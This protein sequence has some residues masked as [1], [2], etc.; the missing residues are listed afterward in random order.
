MAKSQTMRVRLKGCRKVARDR[1]S[2]TLLEYAQSPAEQYPRVVARF[3]Q[4][5]EA[6]VRQSASPKKPAV[7][8]RRRVHALLAQVRKVV[9]TLEATL[10]RERKGSKKRRS[11]SPPPHSGKAAKAHAG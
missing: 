9:D 8:E 6:L 7:K 11:A 10:E 1:D 4:V 3:I 2:K 5:T